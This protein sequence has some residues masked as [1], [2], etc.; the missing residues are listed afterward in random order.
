MKVI[1]SF[2]IVRFC[3]SFLV[4]IGAALSIFVTDIM[5]K[6]EAVASEMPLSLSMSC[7]QTAKLVANRGAI[8]LRTGENTFDRYVRDLQFCDL[9]DALRPEWIPTRD[10]PQCFIGYTCYLPDIENRTD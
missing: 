10:S 4:I 5:V 9:G 7:D 8:V 3:Q 2:Y 1:Y 6:G